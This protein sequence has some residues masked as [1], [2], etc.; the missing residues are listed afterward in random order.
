MKYKCLNCGNEKEKNRC[1][2]G[3]YC[4]NRCMQD[5]LWK[6][7]TIP[8]ILEGKGTFLQVKKYLI[9]TYGEKCMICGQENI[10]NG[11]SLRMQIDHIDGNSDNNNLNNTRLLCPNCH[12]QTETYGSKGIGNRYK[13]ETK[14]NLYLQDYKQRSANSAGRVQPLQ[15]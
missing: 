10:Y 12:S 2:F 15:D 6:T 3:K 14:R 9:E 1:S 13:K 8:K 7:Y 4:N 11:K 5:Y